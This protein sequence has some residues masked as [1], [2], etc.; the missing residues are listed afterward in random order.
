MMQSYADSCRAD[1]VELVRRAAAQ[2]GRELSA[3]ELERVHV[4][5]VQGDQELATTWPA[6]AA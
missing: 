1:A 3:A 4:R 5:I 6:G 2:Q